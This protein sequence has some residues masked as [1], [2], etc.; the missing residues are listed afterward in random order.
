MRA[1]AGVLRR[2][3]GREGGTG[4]RV[5]FVD[6]RIADLALRRGRGGERPRFPDRVA[7]GGRGSRSRRGQRRACPVIGLNR[8]IGASLSLDEVLPRLLD[9]LFEVFPRAER[10]FVLL[11]D[12]SSHR[13]VLRAR[14]IRGKVQPG[15]LR[16]S[17][18]LI[19]QVVQSRRAILSADASADSR[20]NASQ[21]IVD[22]RIRSVMCVPFLNADG[23]VL[24]TS[25]PSTWGATSSPTCRCRRAVWR[26][27]WPTSPARE[28]RPR[29]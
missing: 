28:C 11:T 17:L 24:A 7:T 6:L 1:A 10:G 19:D 29:W 20:F 22:C 26:W 8:A 3:A 2:R 12:P 27:C 18:S 9:G 23:N 13:L 16:L 21:S 5:E 25:R 14:K 15:P 4:R